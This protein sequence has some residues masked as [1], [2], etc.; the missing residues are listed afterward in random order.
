M[1]SN[2]RSYRE[3]GNTIKIQVT[4]AM[5]LGNAEDYAVHGISFHATSVFYAAFCA[6]LSTIR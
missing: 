5:P 3:A 2:E 4:W 6:V 1:D